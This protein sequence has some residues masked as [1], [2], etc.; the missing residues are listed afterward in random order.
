VVRYQLELSL[1]A[2]SRI[3]NALKTALDDSG[4]VKYDIICH[5]DTGIHS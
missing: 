3:S 5:T 1:A 2:Y 4:F